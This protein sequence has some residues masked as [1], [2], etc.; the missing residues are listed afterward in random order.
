MSETT[1][2]HLPDTLHIEGDAQEPQHD[3]ERKLTPREQMMA[4]IAAHAEEERGKEIAQGSVY[5]AEARERGEALPPATF[6]QDEPEEL[7][8][9]PEAPPVPAAPPATPEP[10]AVPAAPPAPQLHTVDLGNGQYT[11]V[12]EA[13]FAQ[14]ARMGALA[15]MALAQAPAAPEPA[16]APVAPPLSDLAR[17]TVQRIQFGSPDEGANALVHYT[18]RLME[19]VPTAP[20]IDQRALID[21]AAQHA[22]AIQQQRTDTA[23]I[24]AEFP[25]IFADPVKQQEAN[26]EVAAIETRDRLLGRSRPPIEIYREAGNRVYDQH[27][28]PRPGSE[29]TQTAP[30]AAP[31]TIRPRAGVEERKRAAPRTTQPVDRRSA[32]PPQAP[33]APSG[34]AIVAWMAKSR[35]QSAPV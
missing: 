3:G 21:A 22:L 5:D 6:E 19:R 4:R 2:L 30:Q 27:N 28:L 24:Q 7:E 12:T 33:Q 9:A 14:L 17:E 29:P 13:Q 10:V 32:M 8:S 34:S 11:Q 18:E 25:A 20:A 35:G 31:V 15:G 1:E 26:A 23:A 16:P